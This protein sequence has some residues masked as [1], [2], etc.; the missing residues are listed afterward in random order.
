MRADKKRDISIMRT[1][2]VFRAKIVLSL[3][4]TTQVTELKSE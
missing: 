3:I 2:Y 4:N 1:H